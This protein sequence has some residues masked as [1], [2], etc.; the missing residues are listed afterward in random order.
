M[1]KFDFLFICFRSLPRSIA[2]LTSRPTSRVCGDTCRM[3]TRGKSSKRRVRPTLRLK[4]LTTAWP[5]TENKSQILSYLSPDSTHFR[6]N[7]ATHLFH[8]KKKKKEKEIK[9]LMCCSK[10]WSMLKCNVALDPC[11][12]E[13]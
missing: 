7:V 13:K 1:L 2:T 11:T 12:Y 6:L 4:R 9:N 3:P 5:T 8:I 10:N